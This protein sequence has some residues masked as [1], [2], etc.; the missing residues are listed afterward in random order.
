MTYRT[1]GKHADHYTIDAVEMQYMRSLI[2]T[3]NCPSFLHLNGFVTRLIR[4][5]PL[6]EQE[7]LFL[8]EHLSSP[9][10]SRYRLLEHL[11]SPP[12]FNGV[13]GTRS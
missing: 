3:P 6:V 13:R 9:R 11:S 4:R 2:V 10:L 5:V 8:P 1:L 7:L 12:F